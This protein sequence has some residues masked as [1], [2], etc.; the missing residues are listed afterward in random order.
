[1]IATSTNQRIRKRWHWTEAA[2]SSCPARRRCR[3]RLV[4][5]GGTST[6]TITADKTGCLYFCRAIEQTD[7][8]EV[9][10]RTAP[11]RELQ[12]GRAKM[13]RQTEMMVEV[14]VVPA[15]WF[16]DHNYILPHYSPFFTHYEWRSDGEA[17]ATA[18]LR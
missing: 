10:M 14:L 1:M 6:T 18:D 17:E 16:V 15:E 4:S 11:T 7:N 12:T 5:Y 2:G 8:E 13:P 3:Q 9:E